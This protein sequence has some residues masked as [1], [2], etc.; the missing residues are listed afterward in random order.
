MR[1][2]D[3]AYRLVQPVQRGDQ[4]GVLSSQLICGSGLLG[5][6][7]LGHGSLQLLPRRHLEPVEHA[8]TVASVTAA[9]THAA[10][11]DH[12]SPNRSGGRDHPTASLRWARARGAWSAR[13]S[14][15]VAH[16]GLIDDAY[17]TLSYARNVAEHL[18]WGMI[19]TEESNTATSPLNVIL[20]A[21]ATWISGVTGALQP[22]VGLGILT[23]ALSAAMA[24]WAA[25]IAR[26]LNVAGAWS[27]AVLAVVFAN[28]FVNSAIGLEV[29]P[30]AAFLTG[31]TAQAVHGRRVA[32]GV[33]AGLL[34]LTRPDLASSS[35][36][37]T[38]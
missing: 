6:H 5:G 36:S 31:L 3:C 10:A 13:S 18:H 15:Y 21:V 8:T 30:I 9:R 14:F 20:L 38:W 33:L 25:Q 27:I 19:P 4:L 11:M 34:V 17:I 2:H 35:P 7:D 16:R 12:R 1:V 24:V 28:P 22:V 26:R 29:V 23:V 32:F 37:C